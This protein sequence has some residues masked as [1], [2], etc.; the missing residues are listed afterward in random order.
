MEVV[1]LFV[2]KAF[3]H[4]LLLNE[5]ARCRLEGCS[6]GWKLAYRQHPEGS[7]NSDWQPVTNTVP[8][9]SI[10]GL[11]VFNMFIKC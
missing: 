11:L 3:D 10:L 9:K 8:Q 4:S 5:M 6:M 7:F 2:S 1:Y